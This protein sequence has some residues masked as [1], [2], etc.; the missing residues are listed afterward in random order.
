MEVHIILF[1]HRTAEEDGTDIVG[2]HHDIEYARTEMQRFMSEWRDN[3]LFNGYTHFDSDFELNGVD[4]V[5][6]G[7]YGSGSGVDHIWSGRVET[8]TVN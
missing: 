3:L 8:R 5:S 1:H 6:F 7:F 4:Y 2:V